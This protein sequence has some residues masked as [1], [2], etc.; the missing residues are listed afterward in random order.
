M[1][2]LPVCDRID[3]NRFR[4]SVKLSGE[5]PFV[6]RVAGPHLHPD[7]LGQ[8]LPDE[9][10]AAPDHLGE[11]FLGVADRLDREIGEI[12]DGC[13]PALWNRSGKSP[14]TIRSTSLPSWKSPRENDP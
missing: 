2:F 8:C 10:V 4:L 3:R 9:R 5:N 11:L 14:T 12:E 7:A 1:V 13:R 6:G